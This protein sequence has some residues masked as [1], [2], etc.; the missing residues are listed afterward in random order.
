MTGEGER[1]M[2]AVLQDIVGNVQQIVGAEIR[3]AKIEARQ[4]VEKATRSVAL[5]I[6]G[7]AIAALALAFFLLACM[8]LLT[9]VVVPWGAALIVA[10][11]AAAIGGALMAAGMKQIRKVT[12]APPKTVGT[13]KENL[14]WA[15]TPTE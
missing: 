14:Q 10:G 1:S 5:L 8:Y 6:V 7:G 4:E 12:V 3:L 11:A 9:M 13:M 2:A 15:K